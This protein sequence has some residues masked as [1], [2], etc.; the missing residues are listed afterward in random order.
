MTP[1]FDRW[2][3]EDKLAKGNPYADGTP[4]WWA[5]EGWR[6]AQRAMSASDSPQV[7]LTDSGAKKM[8]A[9]CKCPPSDWGD[10]VWEVCGEY[11]DDG[12]DQRCRTCD[13]DKACHVR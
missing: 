12:E 3:N 4:I 10:D 1:E 6:A 7:G 5:W 9:G 2:W 13:H 11:Q 8:P